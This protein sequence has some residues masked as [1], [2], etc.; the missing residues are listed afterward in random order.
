MLNLLKNLYIA[1]D[2]KRSAAS[3]NHTLRVGGSATA[4]TMVVL[5]YRLEPRSGGLRNVARIV[6][7]LATHL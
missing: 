1:A 4:G 2:Y 5:V 6:N 7:A 3:L